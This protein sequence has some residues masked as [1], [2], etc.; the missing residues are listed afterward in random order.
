LSV[1]RLPFRHSPLNEA[2]LS[3]IRLSAEATCLRSPLEDDDRRA[4][5]LSLRRWLAVI[6]L[7]FWGNRLDRPFL[8]K[9]AQ[10]SF[11]SP[12]F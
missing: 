2:F 12:S 7:N 1:V 11:L 9:T 3:Y 6:H 8:K 10:Q 5:C 4:F